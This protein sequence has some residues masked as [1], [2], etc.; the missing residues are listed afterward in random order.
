MRLTKRQLKRIIREEYSRLKRRGLIQETG[1]KPTKIGHNVYDHRHAS[2]RQTSLQ[3]YEEMDDNAEFDNY[4][5]CVE[6]CLAAIPPMMKQ[7]CSMG[8]SHMVT[9]D[10]YHLCAPICEQ[11]GCDC[12]M[13]SE[14]VEEMCCGR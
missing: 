3:D 1:R 6:K 7:M 9:N 8:M 11:M 10:I 2:S 14:E 4:D 12:D 5:A 13:V